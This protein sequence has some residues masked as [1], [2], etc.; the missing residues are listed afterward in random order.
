MIHFVL[1][2][3]RHKPIFNIIAENSLLSP[4][5]LF[6]MKIK[7]QFTLGDF[8]LNYFSFIQSVTTKKKTKA[9]PHSEF[10]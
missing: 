7:F 2:K 5:F 9:I 3:T 6:T 1:K 10:L 8:A 4:T